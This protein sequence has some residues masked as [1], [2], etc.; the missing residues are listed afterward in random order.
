MSIYRDLILPL[1]S[2][3]KKNL[4]TY[5]RSKQILKS[6]LNCLFCG[7]LMIETR[8]TK[9]ND[10]YVWKCQYT[11]CVRYK[12]TRPI[13]TDSFIDKCRIELSI[14]LILIH[15]FY[16]D[17]YNIRKLSEELALS[18]HTLGTFFG[19]LRNLCCQFLLQHPVKLGGP[20]V[21]CQIDESL[22]CHKAKY[23]RGRGPSEQVWVFGIVDTSF[24]PGRGYMCVVP[25][26]SENTLLPIIE[27][28]VL[29][30][31]TI[32]SDSWAAYRNISSVLGFSHQMVN[33]RY[34]FV[35]PVTGVHT[36]NVESYWSKQKLRI[37]KMMG[38]EKEKLPLYL[39]E[40]MWRD[41]YLHDNW[42]NLINLLKIE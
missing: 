15:R 17:D 32:W 18:R 29:P 8:Y 4:I 13:R 25:N 26:R 36:Q 9:V 27:S 7:K 28:V 6:S 21:I 41:N 19:K 33:H 30:E 37:K 3:D 12:T 14:V 10:G 16:R 2:G 39:N 34:N 31:T 11:N 22:F 40:W 38:V 1:I 24:T 42:E 35:D 23:H 5:F 20:S